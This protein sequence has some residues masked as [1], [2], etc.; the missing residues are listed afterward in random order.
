MRQGNN[1]QRLIRVVKELAQVVKRS[2][3]GKL[4]KLNIAY[5]ERCQG[6]ELN[7]GQKFCQYIFVILL[8]EPDVD[9]C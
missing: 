2:M 6:I 1:A 9:D 5:L 4:P 3:P 7:P 8:S